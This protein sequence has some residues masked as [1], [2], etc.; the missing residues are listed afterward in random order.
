MASYPVSPLRLAIITYDHAHLKTEQLVHRLLLKR[1]LKIGRELDIKLLGLPF[2]SRP[3][4]PVLL[5]HR[6]DQEKSINTRELATRHGLEFLPCTYDFIPDV[7]DLYLIGGSGILSKKALGTKKI[8]N[9][10]PGIIPSAR[11]LDAF[12]WSILDGVPLGVTIH[13][14][15]AEV[16]AG[17]T[18]AIVETP[19]FLSDTLS[20]LARRHYEL[21]L[22]VASEFLNFLDGRS[23]TDSAAYPESHSR[24]RMSLKIEQDMIAKFDAYKEKFARRISTFGSVN[25]EGYL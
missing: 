16:D 24:M 9:V 13:Y 19:I 18:I 1:K 12:K 4:R 5:A 22:D 20:V 11:G 10:H 21:E 23:N 2:S 3:S 25:R 8:V 17:E 7:A 15:D 14:I 6:P